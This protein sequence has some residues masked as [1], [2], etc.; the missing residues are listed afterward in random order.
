MEK[1]TQGKGRKSLVHQAFF[2]LVGRVIA[3]AFMFFLPVFLVRIFSKHDFGLYRQFFLLFYA[4][5]SLMQFGMTISL[6]S[7][8][9]RYREETPSIVSNTTFFLLAVGTFIALVGGCV[10]LG[11]WWW[12]STSELVALAGVLGVFSGLMV[13]SSGFETLL[14]VEERS[15]HAALVIVLWDLGRGAFLLFGAWWTRSLE[16]ALW[17]MASVALVRYGAYLWYLRKRYQLGWHWVRRSSFVNQSRLAFPMMMQTAA[18]LIEVNLDRYMVMYFYTKSAFAVYTVGSF[19]IPLVDM[20]FTSIA[21][22][23]LP[24]LS[25]YFGA[26]EYE[27]MLVLWNEAIRKSA[28]VLLPLFSVVFLVRKEFMLI[29]F[30]EKYASSIPIFTVY[31]FM[32]PTYI[33]A[34]NLLLQAMGHGRNLLFAG[35]VKPFVV[36]L[37][38]YTGMTYGGLV[39]AITGLVIYHYLAMGGYLWL[40]SRSLDVSVKRLVPFWDLLH[41]VGLLAIAVLA[42]LGVSWWGMTHWFADVSVGLSR[43]LSLFL[44]A[45]TFGLVLLVLL[46]RSS[47]VT[48]SDRA[49][50]R[51]NFKRILGQ[52]RLH[53]D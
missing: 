37:L 10:W 20:V 49:F 18:H 7:V 47:L 32:I 4:I 1:E 45:G 2:L 50:L 24:R 48:A 21:S 31:L 29:I 16:V 13:A 52:V 28:L 51:K 40:T 8:I 25:E 5:F 3:F 39:G 22:V 27:K 17:L 35:V 34:K 15:Q 26:K 11:G 33:L 36:F 42:A 46:V 43:W 53:S 44:K 30:T 23:I 12:Q 14:I 6:P 41:L 19:Q 9:P 38:V